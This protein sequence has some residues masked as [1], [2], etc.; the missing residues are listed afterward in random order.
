[1]GPA[2]GVERGDG[3]LAARVLSMAYGD[4][5]AGTRAR[6]DTSPALRWRLEDP[7]AAASCWRGVTTA[8]PSVYFTLFSAVSPH[9]P[10]KWGVHAL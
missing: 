4:S 7:I 6:G 5:T 8:L 3:G 10:V 1:M 2:D 9:K